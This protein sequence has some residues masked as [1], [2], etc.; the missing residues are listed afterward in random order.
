MIEKFDFK[1][2][3]GFDGS[4]SGLSVVKWMEKADLVCRMGQMKHLEHIVPLRLKSSTFAVYQQLKEEG[5][6]DFSLIKSV[7]YV[8]FATDGF[9]FLSLSLSGIPLILHDWHKCARFDTW[10]E[11]SSLLQVYMVILK[12][13][14]S[15]DLNNLVIM[16]L[17][18]CIR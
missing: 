3:P 8:A 13:V 2:I 5:K 4:A 11:L 15:H 10:N 14:H 16:K 1:L 18:I 9:F 17:L 12:N 6:E 7:L